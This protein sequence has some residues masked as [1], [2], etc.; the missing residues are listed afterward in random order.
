MILDTL[1][2]IILLG[3]GILLACK[4]YVGL[5]IIF[6]T[7]SGIAIYWIIYILRRK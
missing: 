5:S 7:G 4:Q 2:V 6:F 3:L 1:K